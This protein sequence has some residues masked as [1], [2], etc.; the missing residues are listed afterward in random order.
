M[1]TLLGLP[2]ENNG[3]STWKGYTIDELNL[4]RGKSLLRRE[5]GRVQL[6]NQLATTGER[7]KQQGVRGLLFSNGVVA[8]LNKMDYLYLAYRAVMMGVKLFSRRRKRF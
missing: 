6:R 8:G 3:N 5:M 2:E 1:A 4:A 7:A